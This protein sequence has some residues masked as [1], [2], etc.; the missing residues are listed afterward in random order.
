LA[1]NPL[2]T[3]INGFQWGVLD[4]AAPELGKTLV[5]IAVTALFLIVGLWYFRRS[6]PRFADTI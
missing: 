2:T 4:T 3:V 6:E 5:G 1:L